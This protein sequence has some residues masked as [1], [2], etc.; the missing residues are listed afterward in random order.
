MVR[1]LYLSGLVLAVLIP[2]GWQV[3][4]KDLEELSRWKLFG[5]Q[6]S[7]SFPPHAKRH[8]EGTFTSDFT[9]YLDRMKAKDFV[10]WLINTKSRS[11]HPLKLFGVCFQGTINGESGQ[12]LSSPLHSGMSDLSLASQ[13]RQ[14]RGKDLS[15]A[16]SSL[17]HPVFPG[18]SS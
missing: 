3:A 5:S 16:L 11:S 15:I 18:S 6:N 2:P 13:D 4:P 10:H 17:P 1:W 12:Q 9:R 8:S 14:L 7:Q